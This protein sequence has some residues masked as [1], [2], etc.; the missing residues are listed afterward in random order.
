MPQRREGEGG[1]GRVW[2]GERRWVRRRWRRGEEKR[3]RRAKRMRRR[4]SQEEG[5]DVESVSV[6]IAGCWR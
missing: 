1:P 4:R 2:R 5:S 6:S 3:M